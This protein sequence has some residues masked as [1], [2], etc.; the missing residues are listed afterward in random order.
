MENSA[1]CRTP[2]KI[3]RYTYTT[4]G[5]KISINDM[6]HISVPSQ[7]E[8]S[9]QFQD[10]DKP[11][12]TVSILDVFDV[13]I[14]EWDKVGVKGKILDVKKL[15]LVQ[16]SKNGV[17]TEFKLVESVIGD[18][19]ENPIQLDVWGL[20]I[21]SIKKGKT[22]F[23]SP[24]Q[25]RIWG[26]EKKLST[27]L[28]TVVEEIE[29]DVLANVHLDWEDLTETEIQTISVSSI[30]SVEAVE[31]FSLCVQCKR[32]LLQMTSGSTARCDKC[33]HTM[34]LV[35][36]LKSVSA[37]FVVKI[38]DEARITLMSHQTELQQMLGDDNIMDMDV[39]NIA[40][41]ILL[42][43]NIELKYNSQSFILVS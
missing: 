42:L 4:D 23:L 7:T 16:K 33:G 30:F 12:R 1:K 36:C 19:T 31:F 13:K 8:Y 5:Q 9:F 11:V 22:Y 41:M 27:S 39:S 25:V 21:D 32:R 3:Q 2:V 40:E 35:D 17:E 18:E 38:E 28:E 15:K 34:R 29:D 26:D 37:K 43:E 6:C 10:L 24:V 14:C 20:H